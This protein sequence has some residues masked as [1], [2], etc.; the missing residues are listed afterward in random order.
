MLAK[1][2]IPMD[3]TY[4]VIWTTTTWTLP[5]NEAICLNGAFDVFAVVKIGE[6]VPYHGHRAGQERDAMPAILRTT[7]SWASLFPALSSS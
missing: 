7:R 1:H 6:R 2:G 3:K 5:A 4:F